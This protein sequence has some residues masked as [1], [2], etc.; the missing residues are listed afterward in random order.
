LHNVVDVGARPEGRCPSILFSV[1]RRGNEVRE[2]LPDNAKGAVLGTIDEWGIR[3]GIPFER[4][5][6]DFVKIQARAAT[7]GSLPAPI[8]WDTRFVHGGCSMGG[9]VEG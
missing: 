1:E 4:Y 3:R 8:P 2:V 9:S 5:D 7:M 6:V